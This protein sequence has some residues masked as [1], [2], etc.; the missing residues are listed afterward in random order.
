MNRLVV[1]K[2]GEGGGCLDWEFG[3]SGCK[4]LYIDWKNNK[5]LLYSMWSYIQYPV[6]NHKGKNMKKNVYVLYIHM[7]KI[8]D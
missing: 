5:V 2:E 3:I 7:Y 1:A 8:D 6:I 4:L